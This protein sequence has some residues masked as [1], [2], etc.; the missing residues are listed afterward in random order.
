MRRGFVAAVIA[1]SI[2]NAS[3]A[4]ATRIT[5]VA[6]KASLTSETPGACSSDPADYDSFCASGSC[7]CDTYSGSVAGPLLGK[8]TID[9]SFTVDPG[10]SAPS[11]GLGCMPFFGVASFA[12]KR[13]SE[14]ENVT[15]TICSA[16][17]KA[18]QSSVAGGF[19]IKSSAIGE[20]GWGTLH[21]TLN[22]ASSPTVLTL[23]LAVRITP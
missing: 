5:T 15:G 1:A 23:L 10:A 19:G 11:S 7:V 8:G 20:S 4:L 12:A 16:F 3:P 6:V 13:D 17:G 21:G 9:I 14:T 18:H 2:I 22:E